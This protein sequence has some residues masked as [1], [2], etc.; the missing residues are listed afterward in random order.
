MG[1]AGGSIERLK[2]G[3]AQYTRS[4]PKTAQYRQLGW[5]T[6]GFVTTECRLIPVVP[7]TLMG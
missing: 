3:V 1:G 2:G 5:E 4:I 6:S 7:S